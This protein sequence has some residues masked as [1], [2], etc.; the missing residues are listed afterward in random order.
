MSFMIAAYNLRIGRK[1]NSR[2]GLSEDPVFGTP[3]PFYG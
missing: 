3:P 1:W 2:T